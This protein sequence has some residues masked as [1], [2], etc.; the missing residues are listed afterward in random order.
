M[1]EKLDD[2]AQGERPWVPM[3]REFY[4]PFA[5]TL[6]RAQREI[7]HVNQ[8]AEVT[9]QVCDKCGKPMAIKLGRFGRFLSCTGYPE[10]KNARPMEET[11]PEPSDEICETCGKPMQIRTGRY[12]KFLACTDY[13]ECKTSRPILVKLGKIVPEV[14]RGRAGREEGALRSAV[15]RLCPLPGLRLGLLRPAA[16]DPCEVCGGLRIPLGQDKVHCIGCDGELPAAGPQDR[17]RHGKPVR[18][19]P[20]GRRPAHGRLPAR[21]RSKRWHDRPRPDQR[22]R[23]VGRVV[24]VATSKQWHREARDDGEGQEHAP[25]RRSKNGTAATSKT[26][27]SSQ[28]QATCYKDG[29]GGEEDRRRE[30]SRP[31]AGHLDVSPSHTGQLA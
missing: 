12:G 7:Q 21:R 6:E 28:G 5:E 4:G 13:P 18:P 24:R 27:E 20:D 2:I 9:D 10:C 14:R 16:A 17:G 8:A 1:E 25:R 3:M 30:G 19:W 23:R 15:L 11:P 31:L 29:S 22:H 26:G